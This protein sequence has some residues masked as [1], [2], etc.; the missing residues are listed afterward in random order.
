MSSKNLSLATVTPAQLHD[1][2]EKTPASGP[3]RGVFAIAAVATL[4]SL[5]FGYD[6][7]V[8]SG[9]LPY[10]HM[11]FGAHGLGLTS[12]EAGAISGILLLGAAFGALFGGIMSDRWGRRH[13]ITLLAILFFFG[14]VGNALSPNVWVM[15]IFRAVLGFA[16]GGASATVP[17]YL[18]ETA[19]K[20]IRGAIVAVDQLM[21]VTGQ[22]L[23]FSIN[24]LIA[25]MRGGPEL[26]VTADPSGL[27][28]AEYIG[29]TISF[30]TLALMQA[31]R[32]GTLSTAEYH[33]FLAQLTVTAGNG[34]TWRYM[35]VL[36][37]IP[38]IALWIGI[39]LMPESSRWYV[40][41]DRLYEAIGAL[42][43]VRNEAV[44]GPIVDELQIL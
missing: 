3:R 38:A 17:V 18:A 10:M 19:P 5:L 31:S 2:V 32:G 23:A 1:A 34:D 29:Q 43:R 12:L 20:R 40:A 21:I 9:A 42:K 6:T 44:D 26:T 11:P 4:G 7:G 37:S 16:V 28:P 35:I 36:C 14:A 27:L 39:R 25:T 22:L 41:K 30:D 8:I 15:Y 13:N 24:A 33:E